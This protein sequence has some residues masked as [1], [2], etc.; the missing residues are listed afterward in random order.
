LHWDAQAQQVVPEDC[1]RAFSPLTALTPSTSPQA[2]H[3]TGITGWAN[4]DVLTFDQLL[5]TG[6]TLQLDQP[7]TGDVDGANFTVSLE[8]AVPNEGTQYFRGATGFAGPATGFTMP[9]ARATTPVLGALGAAVPFTPTIV[10]QE[11]AVDGQIAVNAEGKSI[12]WQIPYQNVPSS[13]RLVILGIDL[14]LLQ[15]AQFS[16]FA[17]V[18]VRLVGR[19]IFSGG[20]PTQAFLDGQS[21]GAPSLRKDGV[22]PRIDLQ[23]PS[24]NSEKA[25][26]F[27]SW[28]YLAPIPSLTK[29]TVQPP[30]V[31]VLPPSGTVISAVPFWQPNTA[32]AKGAEVLDDPGMMNFQTAI[33]TTRQGLSGQ[34]RPEWGSTVGQVTQD[35][36]VTWRCTAPTPVRPM[37]TV[38]LNYPAVADTP[39][40]LSVQAPAGA[41]PVIAVPTSVTVLAGQQTATFAVTVQG[42]P[43]EAGQTLTIQA[44]LTLTNTIGITFPQQATFSVTGFTPLF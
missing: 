37:G 32:Y 1:R 31:N 15:A 29:L 4:D 8:L 18:R 9:G 10:R 30:A 42:N 36:E 34:S 23:F 6:L 38:T 39:V 19:A 43:G 28:F 2:L 13:Q 21:F 12:T 26:D 40:N 25:S 14:A 35:N 22:T 41:F 3:I 20:P 7:P 11:W 5:A 44:T 27:E 17:R 33:G 16:E 24:G